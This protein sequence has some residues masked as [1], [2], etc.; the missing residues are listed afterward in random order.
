MKKENLVKGQRRGTVGKRPKVRE[1]VAYTR[2]NISGLRILV[3]QLQ[4]TVAVFIQQKTRMYIRHG[5]YIHSLL[6][7][8]HLLEH[9]RYTHF[10]PRGRVLFPCSA[11]SYLYPADPTKLTLFIIYTPFGRDTSTRSLL[12]TGFVVA[13]TS[14]MPIS[15]LS[16][17]FIL[18]PSLF[19]PWIDSVS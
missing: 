16:S 15:F 8:L 12:E 7:T 5:N 3:A 4:P 14:E 19:P 11:P 9:S 13:F 18:V 10:L 6:F 17:W 1:G 2:L